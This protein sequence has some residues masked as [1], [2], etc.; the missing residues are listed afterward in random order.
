MS[1]K[2]HV[3]VAFSFGAATGAA[4]AW[5]YTKKKYEQLV[6]EE[7]DSVKKVFSERESKVAAVN[8]KPESATEKPNITE[9]AAGLY[10]KKYM[11]RPDGNLDNVER[12]T[13][14]HMLNEAPYVISPDEFGEFD[15]YENI[16]LTYYADQVLTDENNDLIDDIPATVGFEALNSFGDYEEDSVFARNDGLKCDYEILR[17]EREFSE[18]AR[19]SSGAEDD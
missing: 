16:S 14:N 9:Y 15:D 8:A 5:Q 3:V 1:K 13:E 18:V 7:I 6:Q 12:E 10:N 4:V 2:L 11:Q 19:N 17:D